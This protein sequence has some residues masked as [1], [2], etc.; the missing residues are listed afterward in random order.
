MNAKTSVAPII[1]KKVALYSLKITFN[2]LKLEFK[3]TEG[4]NSGIKYFVDTEIN[5]GKGSSIGLE[6]QILDDAKHPDAKLRN[7]EG[8]NYRFEE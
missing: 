4:A 7:H 6:Y 1:H 5:Q 3:I 2:K 8:I